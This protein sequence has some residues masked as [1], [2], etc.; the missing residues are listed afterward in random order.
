MNF[1]NGHMSEAERADSAWYR[2]AMWLYRQPAGVDSSGMT[3]AVAGALPE[4]I[5]ELWRT[6]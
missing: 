1:Q 3:G 6:R 4:E 5:H 2:R